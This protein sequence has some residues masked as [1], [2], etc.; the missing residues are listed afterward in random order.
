MQPEVTVV[1]PAPAPVIMQSMQPEVT[2]V[3]PAPAPVIM[4]PMQ[5]EVTVVQPAPAP[6]IM[7]PMQQPVTVVKPVV[8]VTPRDVPVQMQCTYCQ[9]HIL[10]VT[11]PV[12][13]LL[14]WIIFASLF[15]FLI[16]PFCLIPFCVHSC[17]DVEHRCPLCR[18]VLH[19]HKRM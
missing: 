17:N 8:V 6:V 11:K 5:P 3:Q 2:V 1:Q 13:G 4:Q 9:Q 18:Q 14:T 7:Q 12:P 15:V 19:I 10:T 16:W